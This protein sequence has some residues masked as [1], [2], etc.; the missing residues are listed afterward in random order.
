MHNIRAEG[1][2]VVLPLP[3]Y[4][5]QQMILIHPFATPIWLTGLFALLFSAKLRSYRF[6][7]WCY[8]VCFTVL[9]VLHGKNYYLAPVYPMLLAA[10]AV[11]IE[12]AIDGKKDAKLN[13]PGR[14]RRAWLKP[15]IL[16]VLLADGIHLVRRSIRLE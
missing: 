5:L 8:L 14:T 13:E 1:R 16:I 9:F 10:G 7:G 12:S 3:Q 15:V 11:V 2:D 6:L 4:F